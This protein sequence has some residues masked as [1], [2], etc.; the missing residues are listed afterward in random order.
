[1]L[2]LFPSPP[3]ER[4]YKR[5]GEGGLFPLK[6][7]AKDQRKVEIWYQLSSYLLENYVDNEDFG[8]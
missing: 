2:K 7:A 4:R 5:S 6:N 8:S 3:V 1:M